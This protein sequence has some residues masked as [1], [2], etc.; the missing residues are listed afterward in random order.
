MLL[1]GL[2]GGCEWGNSVAFYS[3]LHNF[4]WWN[5]IKGSEANSPLYRKFLKL[6]THIT[7]LLL[8]LGVGQLFFQENWKCGVISCVHLSKS[9]THLYLCI[10]SAGVSAW[11]NTGGMML[12]GSEKSPPSIKSNQIKEFGQIELRFYTNHLDSEHQ[13]GY[14]VVCVCGHP[15]L[16]STDH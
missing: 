7:D 1:F 14:T 12:G 8:I 6:W 15:D 13:T 9:G 10:S 11:A 3:L 5:K 2:S 4:S 16:W